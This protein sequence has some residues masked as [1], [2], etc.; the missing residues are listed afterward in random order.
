MKKIG[1]LNGP[2]LNLVGKREPDVYGNQDFD[3]F[4]LALQKQF[5]DFEIELKQSNVEGELINILQ[6]WDKTKDFIVVNAGSYTHTSIG[7]G[8]AI[9]AIDTPV[10]EV[11]LSN[12]L[13]REDFR[14]VNHIARNAV[15]SITGFGMESYTLALHFIAEQN[16]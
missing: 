9:A 13:A 12:V 15:G 11:H 16:T 10:V 5:S 6:E 3:T 14:Q 7:L 1:I 4:L 2:N 8:D